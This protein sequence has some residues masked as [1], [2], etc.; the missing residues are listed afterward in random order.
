MDIDVAH[1]PHPDHPLLD[2]AALSREVDGEQRR[3]FID[4][5][6]DSI[7]PSVGTTSEISPRTS[8]D[9]QMDSILAMACSAPPAVEA[10]V[11]DRP[12]DRQIFCFNTLYKQFVLILMSVKGWVLH[13]INSTAVSISIIFEISKLIYHL[14]R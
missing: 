13:A 14:S 8:V 10:C 4:G 9:E 12:T 3:G 5:L 7:A 6:N 2:K 11:T 1:N